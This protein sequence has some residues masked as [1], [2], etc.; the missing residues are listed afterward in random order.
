M[1][2]KEIIANTPNPATRE[3]LA[4]DL[5]ALGL[6]S[7]M[8][9]LVHCSLKSLGWV[10]GGAVSVVQA[11]M[12]VIE[13]SGTVIMPTQTAGYSDPE[14]WRN[15]PVPAA[16]WPI[17]RRHMPAFDPLITPTSSMGA[18]AE[19]FRT[20]SGTIRS[21]HPTVSFAAWGKQAKMVTADHSLSFGLGEES[22]L[23]RIYDLGGTVL[24]LGVS[25]DKNTSFHLAEYRIANRQLINCGSPI[26]EN[27][28]RVWKVYQD[29]ELNEEPFLK[30]GDAFEANNKVKH[31]DVALAKSRIFQQRDAV[32]FA[33]QSMEIKR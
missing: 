5:R 27:G 15:P 22:P 25:Y 3:S 33:V 30:L 6:C 16:T 4:Q 17:I 9:V 14:P 11:L 28:E 1:S 24:L 32:D 19:V 2:I 12:D 20:V 26:I 13:S 7:G 8:N 18:V 31:G 21:N 23:A 29:I 10:I